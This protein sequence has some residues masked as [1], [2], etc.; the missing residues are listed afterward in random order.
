MTSSTPDN[1]QQPNPEAEQS[2]QINNHSLP[3]IITLL[4]FSFF[5]LVFFSIY[6][7]RCIVS[8]FLRRNNTQNNSNV[9]INKSQGLD[10]SIVSSFPTFVYSS[11]KSHRRESSRLECAVCL[12]EFDDDDVIRLITMCNHSFHSECI[13]LWLAS[14]TTCPVCR[15]NLD[16]SEKSPEVILEVNDTATSA[17]TTTTTMAHEDEQGTDH[18]EGNSNHHYVVFVNDEQIHG[19]GDGDEAYEEDERERKIRRQNECVSCEDTGGRDDEHKGPA[20]KFSRSHSTGHSIK[21]G[22]DRFT[23]RLPEHVKETLS[24]GHTLTVSCTTFGNF[25]ADV[26]TGKNGSGD[27]SRYSVRDTIKV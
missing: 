4:L 11:V 23:L 7:V 9:V 1:S 18:M 27:L 12:S 25:S 15:L 26:A 24:R 20:E 17:T 2:L 14:H 19:A 10:P 13:D 22:D 6:F 8:I 5:F 21:S 16:P 3:V